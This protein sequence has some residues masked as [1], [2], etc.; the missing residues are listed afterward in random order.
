VALDVKGAGLHT[1]GSGP[2]MPTISYVNANALTWDVDGTR[3]E[4]LT[5]LP[6]EELQKIADGMVLSK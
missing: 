6:V 2:E 4:L 5:N 1:E 3:V